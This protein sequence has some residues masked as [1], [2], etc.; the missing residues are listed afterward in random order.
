MSSSQ[1]VVGGPASSGTTNNV[2]GWSRSDTLRTVLSALIVFCL[3]VGA[4]VLQ[5]RSN[6][7]ATPAFSLLIGKLGNCF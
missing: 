7:D 4:Y 6:G 3:I 2:S 5:A 1:V